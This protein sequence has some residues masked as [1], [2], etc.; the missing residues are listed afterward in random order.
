MGLF[1]GLMRPYPAPRRSARSSESRVASPGQS[2]ARVTLGAREP[3]PPVSAWSRTSISAVTLFTLHGSPATLVALLGSGRAVPP[4]PVAELLEEALGA[5]E[6][7]DL[8]RALPG[9][10]L[11]ERDPHPHGLT[12]RWRGLHCGFLDVSLAASTRAASS[13]MSRQAARLAAASSAP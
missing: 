3:Q 2:R 5:G 12:R 11:V 13:S 7:G 4:D 10:G 6:D 8:D 1:S 9:T